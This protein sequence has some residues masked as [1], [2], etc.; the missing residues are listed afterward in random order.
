MPVLH[1]LQGHNGVIF[2]V[3]YNPITKLICSTS[4]DRTIRLWT[5]NCSD[6]E[7]END[8][9]WRE[10]KITLT[11]T[12]FGHTARIWRSIIRNETLITI[13]EDSL[14]CIWSLN[15][16]LLHK[17]CAHHGAAIWSIDTSADD[18]Y[19]FT[20]GADGAVH[21]WLLDNNY[22]QKVFSI[23]KRFSCTSPKYVCYL[24]NGNFLVFNE[25][26]N[27]F[28]VNKLHNDLIESLYLEKYSS[29]C[30]MEV[31]LCRSFVCFASRD[32][33]VAIYKA[34][35][36][37]LE[38]ILEEKIMNSQIFSVQ[39][40]QDNKVIAC[41][42]NG[43]LKIFIFDTIGNITIESICL[44][45]PSR[46]RW[47]TAAVLY[48]RL[49]VCGDRAGNMHIFKLQEN[50][51]H[52]EINMME[53][54]NKPI[55]TFTKVHGKIGI[56]N[57]LIIGSKLISSGR[58]GMLRFY[59][60]NNLEN[61]TLLRSLHKERMPMD[62][63]SGSLKISNDI[64][65]LGFKEV[66]FL[67]YSMFYHRTV[68]RIPCG[69]G[70]RSWDCMLSGELIRFLYIRN[71]RVYV[72]EFS[73]NSIKSPVLLNGFHTKEVC[74]IDPIL[75]LDNENVLI[76]GGEDGS[77][78]V[79]TVSNVEIKNHLSF[80]MLG[81]FNGHISSIKS[82]VSMS[83][84]ST[85]LCS[86]NLV[87]S[88]G[89]RAQMKVWE[90]DIKNSETTLKDSDISCFD[91]TSHMLYGF[92]QLRKK[93]LQVNHLYIIQPETRYMDI[94][95]YRDIN[96]VHYILPF[97]ACA[98]G[99]VR[100]FL[101]NSNTKCVS[102][103]VH[104]K[105]VD[106]CIVKISILKCEEKVILLTMS[107]DGVGRL[108]DFTEVVSIISKGGIQS[109]D[110]ELKDCAGTILAKFNLHQSGINSYDIKVIKKD[111]YLLATGGDDNLFNLTHFKVCL[112]EDDNQTRV[113][114]LSKWNTSTVHIAQIT[115]IKFHGENTIFSVGLD[116]K[117][118]MYSY[119][120]TNDILSVK[121]L[122]T[123][124]TFVTDVKGLTLWDTPKGEP[125][126]CAYGKGFEVLL[127]Q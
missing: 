3:I 60:L 104:A 106:R 21:I 4:D 94:A 70:H 53:A 113:I 58:D 56:Q 48:K 35:V 64:L 90:I 26:G 5:I 67:V 85:L 119:N 34:T 101:Y 20:G 62:W 55:Q 97:I 33:Y 59:E 68:A 14:M 102:L 100:I 120:F 83:L 103:K 30:V 82:I 22:T 77:L 88:V 15:G 96:N 28:V 78:R 84:Q 54:D 38:L 51:L 49:L 29:Y 73:L 93:Q 76:S 124:V 125:A 39:W 87:F 107:T 126:I 61:P 24:N 43:I 81:I 7:N 69:G 25:D 75:K 27:L 1:R 89:G 18:K 71:K 114:L 12:M 116:Q 121:I 40:L 11:R 6:K 86:K 47:L 112:S 123:I 92:D 50:V 57:F 95:I 74:C 36:K 32:G 115:G 91:V 41:G 117:I 105:I 45:P 44:L 99:F 37:K 16:K 42:S 109:D 98:D 31:S 111:E 2:S 65:V 17:I 66:E 79:S 52:E 46:E 72:F 8:I 108:I 10:A 9:N 118:N 63:I 19:V 127:V 23:P 110:L 80:R 122:K 13:G